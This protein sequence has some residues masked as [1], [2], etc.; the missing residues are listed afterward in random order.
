MSYMVK[1]FCLLSS[2]FILA[3]NAVDQKPINSEMWQLQNYNRMTPIIA[4]SG[5]LFDGGMEELAENGIKTIVDVLHSKKDT[6][7]ARE[8][9]QLLGI[10]YI[11]IPD[12]SISKS[13]SKERITALTSAIEET[14]DPLLILCGGGQ[15]AGAMWTAYSLSKGVDQKIAFKDGHKTGM[16]KRFEKLLRRYQAN[17]K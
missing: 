6:E 11:N 17:L 3:C 9:A 5:R 12:R 1:V 8:A 16:G 4:T 7:S 2:F 14:S 13:F 10:K 15:L